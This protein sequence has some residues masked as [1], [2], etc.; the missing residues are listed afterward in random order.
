M[1]DDD[2][3][4][5]EQWDLDPKWPA[6]SLERLDS[7]PFTPE[8]LWRC[9][10]CR[11]HFIGRDPRMWGAMGLVIRTDPTPDELAEFDRR[12]QAAKR[13]V[14]SSPCDCDYHRGEFGLLL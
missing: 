1:A 2:G 7:M 4:E 8:V 14:K 3:L 11:G 5:G 13:L 12:R 6:E 9:R 10:Q